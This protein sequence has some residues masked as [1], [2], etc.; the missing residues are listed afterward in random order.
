MWKPTTI[1]ASSAAAHSGSQSRGSSRR[2]PAGTPV[3]RLTIL[4]PDL[5]R[6][7]RPRPPRPRRRASASAPRR[8]AGRA[9]APWISDDQ[10][11]V[12]RAR[13]LARPA[14]GPR[15]MLDHM[16]ERRVDDLGPD[17]L[18]VEVRQ[19]RAGR[20]GRRAGGPTARRSSRPS[21]ALRSRSSAA[22]AGSSCRRRG[23]SPRRR[24]S[25]RSAACAPRPVGG[26]I[27]VQRSSGSR[28]CESPELRPDLLHR[29]LLVRG[30]S[31]VRRA[32]YL[33]DTTVSNLAS[34]RPPDSVLTPTRK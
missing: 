18:L 26:R 20:P 21:R 25:S 24:R 29:C 2:S 5:G 30:R 27:C 34:G 31:S 13:R 19:A 32:I 28:K 1:P 16:P 17:A 6:V 33:T 11:L 8:R 10:P 12:L 9:R 7:L 23:R 4:Q 14:G 3:G 22:C 15:I